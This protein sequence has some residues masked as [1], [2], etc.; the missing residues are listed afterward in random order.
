MDSEHSAASIQSLIDAFTPREGIPLP[1]QGRT[2][3]RWKLLSNVAA[4]HGAVAIKLFEA[5]ADA[6][7]ILAE[8]EQAIPAPGTNWAVWAAEPPDARVRMSTVP[9]GHGQAHRALAA[10]AGMAGHAAPVR[11]HGRK[12]WCSGANQVSHALLT[13]WDEAGAARLVAIDLHAPGVTV[14][15]DG[16]HAVG[17]RDTCSGD[18]VM[19]HCAALCLGGPGA[20]YDRPGFW[21]G[22]AGIAACWYG[23]AIPLALAVLGIVQC[24]KD[25]HAAAHLAAIDGE[26]HAAAALLRETA[27]WID[28]N[29]AGDAFAAAMRVRAVV[30]GAVQRA[31]HRAGNVLGAGPLCRNDRLARLYADLP[32]FM[33]QSHAERDLAALGE[34][35]AQG[36]VDHGFDASL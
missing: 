33:R 24:R 11:L 5:H 16:W 12:A 7:A 9:G 35:L 31:I 29:P 8:V 19:E 36:A 22:G 25:P 4:A 23:A 28:D 34:R 2:L 10:S 21:Q 1:G 20:Y 3:E 27:A 13:C 15:T 30:E 17:M 26:L 32:V 14:T 6:L 18:V